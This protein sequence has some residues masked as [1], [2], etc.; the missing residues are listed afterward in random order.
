MSVLYT[1]FGKGGSITGV[2]G[3][4][5]QPPEAKEVY[6]LSTPQQYEKIICNVCVVYNLGKGGVHNKLWQRGVRN[7]GS[8]GETP[9]RR[10]PRGSWGVVPQPPTNFYGFHIKKHSLILAHFFIEKGH[11]VM[12]SLWT[13]QKYFCSLCLKAEAW[14]K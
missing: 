10:R 1:S 11:A 3:R 8:G 4:N 2:C 5:P 12:Q 6:V 9:S 7:R 13:M 14:L